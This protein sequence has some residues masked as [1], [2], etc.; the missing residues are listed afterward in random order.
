MFVFFSLFFL[1]TILY[2]EYIEYI[3]KILV[4]QFVWLEPLVLNYPEKY[5]IIK[6]SHLRSNSTNQKI[7]NIL[8]IV[9]VDFQDIKNM[10][11]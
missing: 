4:H 3:N 2:T 1:V 7:I 6:I 8:F 5:S 10:I 11:L 9:L